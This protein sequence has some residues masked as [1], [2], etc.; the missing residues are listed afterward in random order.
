MQNPRSPSSPA[1]DR[2]SLRQDTAHVLEYL[3]AL[4]QVLPAAVGEDLL[5]LLETAV[6]NPLS[7]ELLAAALNPPLAARR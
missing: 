7:L 2:E 5:I 4:E 6:A 1:L 3:R